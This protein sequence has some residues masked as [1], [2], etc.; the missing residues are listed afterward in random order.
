MF[1]I[2]DKVVYPMHGAGTIESIEE[3]VSRLGADVRDALNNPLQEIVAL[4]YVA[5]HAPGSQNTEKALNAI[6][7]AAKGMAGVVWGLE[8]QLYQQVIGSGS[9]GRRAIK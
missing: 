3:K 4:V 6:E 5:R 1:K 2:G 8:D 9:Y 7:S